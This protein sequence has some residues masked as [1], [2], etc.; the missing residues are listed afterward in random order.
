[1]D[2]TTDLR[3]NPSAPQLPGAPHPFAQTECGRAYRQ[4]LIIY[5]KN[6]RRFGHFRENNQII[7]SKVAKIALNIFYKL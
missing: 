2:T 4:T 7:L 1:M 5:K 3:I 6:S